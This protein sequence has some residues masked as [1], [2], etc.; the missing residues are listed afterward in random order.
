M[1]RELTETD[2]AALGR[3]AE[4]V[5]TALRLLKG[6]RPS[7]IDPETWDSAMRELERAQPAFEVG[8]PGP[9]EDYRLFGTRIRD[10]LEAFR[11]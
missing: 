8:G 11:R 4:A 6:R 10:A 7:D 9:D 2:A 1:S 5:K 3:A